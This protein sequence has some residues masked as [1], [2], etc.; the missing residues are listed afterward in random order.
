MTGHKLKSLTLYQ[1][2]RIGLT[3][4]T[5]GKNF[6]E[7]CRSLT[8]CQGK[9]IKFEVSTISRMWVDQIIHCSL[10]VK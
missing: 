9:R 2:K 8:N 4:R 1:G 3:M 6:A 5:V 7:L 10:A